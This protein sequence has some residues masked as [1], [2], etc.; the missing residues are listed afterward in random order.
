MLKLVL[1]YDKEA[2]IRI[3]GVLLDSKTNE[4]IVHFLDEIT[5]QMPYIIGYLEGYLR[6]KGAKDCRFYGENV[7]VEEVFSNKDGPTN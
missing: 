7:C 6:A 4:E 5:D 1:E 2:E 3:K